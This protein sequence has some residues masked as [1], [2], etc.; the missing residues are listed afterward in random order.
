MKR[1]SREPLF[2]VHRLMREG[3]CQCPVCGL[4][5]ELE[6]W[7]QGCDGRGVAPKD[8][9]GALM[10]AAALLMVR[11]VGPEGAAGL[12]RRF[13]T[14]VGESPDIERLKWRM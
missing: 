13:A 8:V 1:K 9:G 3:I 5:D 10:N 12:L 11:E 6:Q 2:T 7:R 14:A 4:V